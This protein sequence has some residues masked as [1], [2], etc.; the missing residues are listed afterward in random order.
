MYCSSTGTDTRVLHVYAVYVLEYVCVCARVSTRAGHVYG[1][2]VRVPGSDSVDSD[3][4]MAY[5]IWDA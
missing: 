1:G 2:L 3:D 4:A 5:N